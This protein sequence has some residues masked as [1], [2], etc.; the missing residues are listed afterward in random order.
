MEGEM[1]G[2]EGERVEGTDGRRDGGEGGRERET[3]RETDREREKRELELEH[4]ILQG[5]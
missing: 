4:F 5:L 2:R 1:V 3:P